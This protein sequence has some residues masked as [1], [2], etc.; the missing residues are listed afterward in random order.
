MDQ[1]RPKVMIVD[2]EPDFRE[3]FVKRFSRRGL[4]VVAADSGPTALAMLPG[5]P[6]DVMILD[7]KMPRMD[8]IEVLKEVKRRHPEIEVIMLTGHGSVESGVQGMTHGAFDYV[9]KPFDLEDL[10]HK[11]SQAYERKRLHAKG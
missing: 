4:D 8:G 7:V 1:P 9:L 10:L 11:I 3:L 2:D 5:Q 6:V